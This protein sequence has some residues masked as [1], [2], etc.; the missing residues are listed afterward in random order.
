ML[1][2]A[3]PN[4]DFRSAVPTEASELN[5]PNDPLFNEQW[6]LNNAG[7]N[8]GKTNADVAALKAWLKTQGSSEV[9]VHR[10]ALVVI[11]VKAVQIVDVF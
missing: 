9:V 7:Q 5:S 11:G 10:V 6:A 8:G 1:R 3:Q 4:E 2:L